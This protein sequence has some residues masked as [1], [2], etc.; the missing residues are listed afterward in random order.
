VNDNERTF[1]NCNLCEFGIE[2]DESK[3]TFCKK[4]SLPFPTVS[5]FFDESEHYYFC[6]FCGDKKLVKT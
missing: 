6:S 4:C 2:E 3:E 5:Y 1:W